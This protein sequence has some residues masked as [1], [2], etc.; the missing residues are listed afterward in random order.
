MDKNCRNLS[1]AEKGKIL[2]LNEVN[3]SYREIA[4]YL[5][6]N[7]SSIRRFIKKFSETS[8]ISHSSLSGR[9]RMTDKR[10]DRELKR[11]SLKNLFKTAAEVRV[12]YII[13]EKRPIS[14][15]TTQRKLNEHGLLSPSPA[16]QPL[17]SKKN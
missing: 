8:E 5:G 4:R 7:E 16:A 17:F 6:F 13:N 12:E 3:L 14:I 10:G 2:G 1:L 15:R 9:K 11:I